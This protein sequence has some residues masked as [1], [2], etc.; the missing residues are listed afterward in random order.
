MSFLDV[1]QKIGSVSK[2]VVG[3]AQSVA[4]IIAYTP[5][6]AEFNAALNIIVTLEHL[7]PNSGGAAKEAVAVPAVQNLF[8]SAKPDS[9]KLFNSEIVAALNKFSE[10]NK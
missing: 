3:V 7:L 2:Q 8:P 9:I 5:V 4:P 10:S 6:G 1:L